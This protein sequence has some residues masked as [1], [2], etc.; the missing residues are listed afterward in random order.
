MTLLMKQNDSDRNTIIDLIKAVLILFVILIH[1]DAAETNTLGYTLTLG[2][3]VPLFITLSGYTFC[4]ATATKSVKD[5]YDIGYLSR[6][7]FRYSIPAYITMIFYLINLFIMNAWPDANNAVSIFFL[8]DFGP[9]AYYRAVMIQFI[10]V[11]PLIKMLI[12]KKT[13]QGLFICIVISIALEYFAKYFGVDDKIYR[14]AF[15]RY[16]PHVAFGVLIYQLRTGAVQISRCKSFLCWMVCLLLGAGYLVFPFVGGTI[17]LFTRWSTHAMPTALYTAAILY[18]LLGVR[19]SKKASENLI[20]RFFTSIGKSSYHIMYAQMILYWF[21][22]QSNGL[23][24]SVPKGQWL[25]IAF[26]VAISFIV[27]IF[28]RVVDNKVFGKL[29]KA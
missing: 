11:F 2:M 17:T 19:I 21:S 13:V 26:A 29:Y 18:P 5:Q 8:G 20:V 7:Y 3:A 4:F 15:F 12:Q 27:G 23:L 28:F 1:F 10:L 22:Y 6:K 24:Y 16:I 25:F 9:G 14:I